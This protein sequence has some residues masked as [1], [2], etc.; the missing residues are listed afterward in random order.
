M[1]DEVRS[2]GEVPRAGRRAS[3]AFLAGL[4]AR[5]LRAGGRLLAF[6]VAARVFPVEAVGSFAYWLA[7]GSL[8]S[9]LADLGL[10]EHIMRAVPADRS[11]G[12]VLLRQAT[13]IRVAAT[14]PAALVVLAGAALLGPALDVGAAGAFLF[15]VAIGASDYLGAAR[16]AQGRFGLEMVETALVALGALGAAAAVA[17]SGASLAVFETTL[18]G[19]AAVLAGLRL[20]SLAR[21]P[22]SGPPERR[23]I[24]ILIAARWLWAKA[25]LGWAFLDATVLFLA[26]LSGSV[27]VALFASAARLVGFMT[28]PLLALN[29]VFTPA[30]AHERAGSPDDFRSSVLRLNLVGMLLV[31]SG[32]AACGLLGGLALAGFGNAYQAAEPVLLMLALAFAIHIGVLNSVPLVV[33]GDEQKLVVASLLGQL[34]SLAACW[35]MAPRHGALGAAVAVL[36]GLLTPKLLVARIY[37]QRSLPVASG[38]QTLVAAGTVAW[39]ASAAAASGGARLGILL[40]GGLVAGAAAVRLLTRTRILAPHS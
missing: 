15:G 38:A 11:A 13:L 33:L 17:A 9:V 21:N 31:P 39:L 27:E 20:F 25:L 4:G 14:V 1:I 18:G 30:L 8:A 29:W 23:G 35:V 6:F 36:L 32:V 10:A 12:S 26:Y 24:E 37:I 19:T 5:A 16:R 7:A 40:A 22:V 2:P 28:Q 34:V 3:A